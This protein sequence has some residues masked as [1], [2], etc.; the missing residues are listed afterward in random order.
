MNIKSKNHGCFPIFPHIH[1]RSMVAAIRRNK[2]IQITIKNNRLQAIIVLDCLNTIQVIALTHIIQLNIKSQFT[3]HSNIRTKLNAGSTIP[4]GNM[5]TQCFTGKYLRK[6]PLDKKTFDRISIVAWPKLCKIFQGF[7]IRTS[8]TTGTQHHRKIRVL[9][10]DSVQH[11]IESTHIINIQMRLVFF[12][13][14]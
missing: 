7:I 12:Q 4:S 11:F 2:T 3:H 1:G 6:S 10:L 14:H 9:R 8:A 13:I 5:S